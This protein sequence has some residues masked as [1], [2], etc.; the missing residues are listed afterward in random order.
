MDEFET[1]MPTDGP[2][3]RVHVRTVADIGTTL[4]HARQHLSM[5]QSEFSEW[6][7]SNRTYMSKLET[8]VPVKRLATLLAALDAVGLELVIQTKGT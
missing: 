3:V 1:T 6:V 4:A 8:G 5:S 7:G 2:P